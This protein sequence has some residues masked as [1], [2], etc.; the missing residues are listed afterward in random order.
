MLEKPK[1]E[2]QKIYTYIRAMLVLS[3]G[4]FIISFDILLSYTCLNDCP[5]VQKRN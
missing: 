4:K 3:G 2:Y 1:T 5:I